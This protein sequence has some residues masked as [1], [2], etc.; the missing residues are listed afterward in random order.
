MSA[1]RRH[2][3]ASADGSYWLGIPYARAD[4]VRLTRL[5]LR[6][7]GVRTRDPRRFPDAWVPAAP[8]EALAV[9]YRRRSHIAPIVA[10]C[11]VLETRPAHGSILLP[12]DRLRRHD[13]EF[14]RPA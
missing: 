11:R 5:F 9:T 1:K 14:W 2:L 12:L 8:A 6:A 4:C 10:G 13:L 3:H 7:Q